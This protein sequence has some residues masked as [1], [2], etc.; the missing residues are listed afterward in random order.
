VIKSWE[1]GDG[2]LAVGFF[3]SEDDDIQKP[4][5]GCGFIIPLGFWY[6]RDDR[7]PLNWIGSEPPSDYRPQKECGPTPAG[8]AYYYRMVVDGSG[9]P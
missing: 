5:E 4:V 1:V 7:M 3:E 9:N 2:T 6:T 8:L